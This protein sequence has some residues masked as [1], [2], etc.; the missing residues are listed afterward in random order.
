[1]E[2]KKKLVR[3]GTSLGIVIDKVILN[4]FSLKEGDIVKIDLKGGKKR[5]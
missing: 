2:I 5:K 1:M 4:F 3:I